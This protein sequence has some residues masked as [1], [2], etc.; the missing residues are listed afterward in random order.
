[1][2]GAEKV[3]EMM[4]WF[5]SQY[6]HVRF[7]DLRGKLPVH[8]T[9]RYRTI[10]MEGRRGFCFHHTGAWGSVESAAQY[11]VGSLGWPGIGYCLAIERNGDVCICWDLDVVSYGQ[12]W[13]SNAN[14]PETILEEN[15]LWIPV[16]VCGFFASRDYR[17][18]HGAGEPTVK[19]MMAM[20]ALIEYGEKHGLADQTGHFDHGKPA[21]PGDV[22]RGIVEAAQWNCWIKSSHDELAIVRGRLEALT[23]LGYYVGHIDAGWTMEARSALTEFQKDAGIDVDG[24]WGPQSE[25]AVRTALKKRG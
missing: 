7:V 25:R 20:L 22:L 12:G 24:Y 5:S 4:T 13:A 19:Q 6:P 3:I 2:L 23:A 1:M 14:K 16:E 8:P 9:K 11:H 17:Y 15:E 18:R 21:C 10:Q